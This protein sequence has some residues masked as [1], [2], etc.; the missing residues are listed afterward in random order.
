MTDEEIRDG[1]VEA[2]AVVMKGCECGGRF[3]HVDGIVVDTVVGGERVV[4]RHLHGLRCARCGRGA[5]NPE[6]MR[7]VEG[8][9]G[10]DQI[11]DSNIRCEWLV[12][13]GCRFD[14]W[15][16]RINMGTHHHN[17]SAI[18]HLTKRSFDHAGTA[19]VL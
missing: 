18:F 1:L 14:R 17:P 5:L 12:D 16:S 8:C 7:T 11:P 2:G 10:N 6:S 13:A 9:A 4:F 19:N 3:E 15:F